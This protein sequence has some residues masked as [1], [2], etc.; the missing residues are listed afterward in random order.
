MGSLVDFLIFLFSFH[1]VSDLEISN[2][3]KNAGIVGMDTY[4]YIFAQ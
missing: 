3:G 2:L 4:D 1:L